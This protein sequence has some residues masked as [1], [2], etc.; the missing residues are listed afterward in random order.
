MMDIFS[1][2]LSNLPKLLA[3]RIPYLFTAKNVL[4]ISSFLGAIQVFVTIFLEPHGTDDYQVPGHNFLLSGYALCFVIPFFIIYRIEKWLYSLQNQVWKVYQEIISK[5]IL[6]IGIATASYF[7]NITIINSIT[8]SLERWIEHMLVFAWP[9]I[10]L[11]IPFM[12]II[13]AI[14]YKYHSPDENE[15]IITG[16]NQDDV[17]EITESQFIY[18]ESDQNYV[19][20]YFKNGKQI[21]KK[22]IRSPLQAVEDQLGFAVRVHRSYLINPAYLESLKG[23]KRKRT[24]ILKGVDSIIPVSPNFEEDSILKSSL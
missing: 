24:A 21:D 17:L 22:L 2:A 13:Y 3:K 8:P 10:P 11:F 9:Y 19:T 16:Q 12:I 6:S 20:V 15:L 23:N 5:I 1:K 4:F 14:L 18:A 7:Y